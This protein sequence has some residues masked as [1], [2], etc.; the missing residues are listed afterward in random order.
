ML[1]TGTFA[2]H[3]LAR[4]EEFWLA[5]WETP[6]SGPWRK[7]AALN[8]AG[9]PEDRNAAAPPWRDDWT[10]PT[11]EHPEPEPFL[12]RGNS[13]GQ[14]D[15]FITHTH[16]RPN[17]S[18]PGILASR[19]SIPA[20]SPALG[21]AIAPRSRIRSCASR[22]ARRIKF[23][24]NRKGSTTPPSIQTAYRPPCRRKSNSPLSAPFPVSPK[25]D[26]AARLCCGS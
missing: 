1:T 13:H 11:P 7:A 12:D 16:P 8:L 6:P 15:C 14:A 23:F 4:H 2:R 3:D 18:S 5:A 19:R 22:S 25:P 10:M 17:A 20:Q 24:S 26:P 21:R 9:A